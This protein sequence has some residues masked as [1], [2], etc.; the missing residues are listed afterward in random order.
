M[1]A[2]SVDFAHAASIAAMSRAENAA[3]YALFAARTAAAS[4]NCAV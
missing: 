4:L 3:R 1:A 2:T